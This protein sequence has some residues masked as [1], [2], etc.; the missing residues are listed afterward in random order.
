MLLCA[1]TL[2]SCQQPTLNVIGDEPTKESPQTP[3]LLATQ[4]G[5]VTNAT[6]KQ[7]P[8][9]IVLTS[10]SDSSPDTKPADSGA[11]DRDATAQSMANAPQGS[12]VA[13]AKAD[14]IMPEA[15]REVSRKR[16]AT[17]QVDKHDEKLPA[18]NH[19]AKEIPS[20]SHKKWFTSFTNAIEPIA[21]DSEDEEAWEAME[22]LLDEGE[23]NNWLTASIM[24]A[25]DSDP[26]AEYEYTPLH[27]AAA[28]G[29]L[30]LVGELVEQWSITVDITTQNKNT[31]L[32]LAAA[33]GHLDVVQFLVNHGADP[34]LTD[35]NEGSA[36]HYA[37]AGR[38]EERNRE[39]IEYLVERGADDLTKVTK[40]GISLLDG[41]VFSSNLAVIEYWI[42]RFSHNSNSEII[43]LTKRACGMAKRLK[44]EGERHQGHII[45]M[46]KEFLEEESH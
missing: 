31:P 24:C 38:R 2:H 41:A 30:A 23:K 18:T 5:Q 13:S 25:N 15:N 16:P 11:L 32:H 46:L 17:T 45:R 39:V 12:A 29:L 7:A 43:A 6:K 22:K 36:L 21:D 33:R 35:S 28:K 34:K 42:D 40:N 8:C 27:Y 44:K 14:T 10:S 37:A 3:Q 1:L 20:H 26:A 9:C 19:A 4:S